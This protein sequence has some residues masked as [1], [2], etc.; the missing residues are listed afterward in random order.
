MSRLKNKTDEKI[1]ISIKNDSHENDSFYQAVG[2]CL[3][4]GQ[5][6]GMLP[7][8]GIMGKDEN[9]LEFRWT[10]LRAVYALFFLICGIVDSGLGIRRLYRLG[11]S[12]GFAEALLYFFMGMLKASLIF[13]IAINWKEIM[14]KWKECEKPF[15]NQPY[16]QL[17]GWKLKTKIRIIFFTITIAFT[18]G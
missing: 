12:I 3:V 5:F 1:K 15:L 7:I 10:S 18:C 14:L 4:Y 11:F 8:T 17:K 13:K 6:F 2:P 16:N 9:S